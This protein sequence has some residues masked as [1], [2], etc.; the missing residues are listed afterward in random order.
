MAQLLLQQGKV[1][2]ALKYFERAAELSRTEG[3]ITNALEY[4]EATRTQLEVSKIALSDSLLLILLFFIFVAAFANIVARYKGSAKVSAAG[5]Q[6]SRHGRRLGRT[7]D[8]INRK[9]NFEASCLV[10][11]HFF[12]VLSMSDSIF[13]TL[14]PSH[15]LLILFT[16]VF[17]S[18]KTV[19]LY[20]WL[21]FDAI[22]STFA[23]D[24]KQD[25]GY[26]WRLLLLH[27]S[28]FCTLPLVFSPS[29]HFP[30]LGLGSY[31]TLFHEVLYPNE[32]CPFV[33][34]V[35][36]RLLVLVFFGEFSYLKLYLFCLVLW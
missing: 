28:D 7:W 25:Q 23:E 34:F 18:N 16:A 8:E 1:T 9:M 35:E 17:K 29:F 11:L 26:V 32:H 22:F 24:I 6:T 21:F 10:L 36:E 14:F 12:H 2:E 19:I 13:A 15:F 27:I 33:Y 31:L 20:I 30:L 4:A 5:K 3:E